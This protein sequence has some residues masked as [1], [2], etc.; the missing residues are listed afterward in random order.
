MK[1]LKRENVVIGYAFRGGLRMESKTVTVGAPAGEELNPVAKLVQIACMY[2]SSIYLENGTRKVN[3]KSIMGMMAL[4][5]HKGMS[6]TIYADGA[7]EDAA[8]RSMEA[9]LA[10]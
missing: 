7:D 5:L 1:K 3:A 4:T 6:V 2:E 9:Y 8:M 10:C